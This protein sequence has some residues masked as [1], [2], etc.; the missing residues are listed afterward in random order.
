MVSGR[1]KFLDY[2]RPLD[3]QKEGLARAVLDLRS[4]QGG[5]NYTRFVIVGVARTGS[6]MLV[7]RLNGHT[8]AL[9]FGELFR[10]LESVGWDVAPFRSYQNRKLLTLYRSDPV[11]FLERCVF[12]RWPSSYRAVGFKLFY[13]HAR[14]PQHS[15]VWDYLVQQPAIRILH[16]KRRNVLAQY[17]S[18]QLA[19]RTNVWSSPRPDTS[20]TQCVQLD[21]G[22]CQNHFA[23]VR[24]LEE[25]CDTLFKNHDLKTVYYEDLDHDSNQEM[26][27][28]QSFLGL[29]C[30][31][32]RAQ[33]ARQQT[34]PLSQ[35]ISNYAELRGACVGTEWAGFFEHPTEP[36][37]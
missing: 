22:A 11:A 23:W 18:L 31:V 21:I 29:R 32:L 16:I 20:D 10:S 12:R 24:R 27:A 33:T 6:T 25:E 36:A 1:M 34:R 26:E 37:A 8:Q 13:Y 17:V 28:V 2:L 19:H 9:V 30:E 7:S 15:F 14:T 5:P 35:V 3:A 4:V